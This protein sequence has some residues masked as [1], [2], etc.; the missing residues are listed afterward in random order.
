MRVQCKWHTEAQRSKHTTQR[1]SS[2]PCRTRRVSSLL[3][4]FSL[5]ARVAPEMQRCRARIAGLALAA[6]FA[7]VLALTTSTHAADLVIASK[8]GPQATI[9]LAPNAG[10]WEQRAATDLQKYIRLMS[11]AEPA[12][13]AVAPEAGGPHV[14]CRT[15]GARD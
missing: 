4:M 14:V 5:G 15:G 2:A 13:A 8:S 10:P 11:G 1:A 3:R 7:S 9:V 6:V 12:I